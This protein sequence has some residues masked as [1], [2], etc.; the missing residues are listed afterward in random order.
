MLGRTQ[1]SGE[2][3]GEVHQVDISVLKSGQYFFEIEAKDNI[4][5]MSFI[6]K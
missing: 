3:K 6:K 2:S 1:L 5:R 4:Q